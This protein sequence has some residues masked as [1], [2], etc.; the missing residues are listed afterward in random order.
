M[1]TPSP[2]TASMKGPEVM[3]MRTRMKTST[4]SNQMLMKRLI[5][6]KHLR[7]EMRK[8]S[9]NLPSETVKHR[10]RMRKRMEQM[11]GKVKALK[12]KIWMVKTMA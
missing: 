10:G 6:M 2:A 1:T 8:S 3:N 12:M 11:I 9:R 5:A 4:R 7:A